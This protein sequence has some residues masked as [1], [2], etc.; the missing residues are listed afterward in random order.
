[1]NSILLNFDY[2]EDGED[3]DVDDDEENKANGSFKLID[4]KN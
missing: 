4:F 2:L 1:M 3:D